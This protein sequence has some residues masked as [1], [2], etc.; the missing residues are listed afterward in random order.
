MICDC[1]AG[2]WL[3]LITGVWLYNYVTDFVFTIEQE[4]RVRIEMGHIHS[5]VQ[6]GGAQG[7]GHRVWNGSPVNDGIT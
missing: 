6:W 7:P 5:V 1:S 2:V 3:K 4:I